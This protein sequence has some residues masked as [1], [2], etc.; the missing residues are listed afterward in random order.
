M[1]SDIDWISVSDNNWSDGINGFE[2]VWWA[3]LL[4]KPKVK[5]TLITLPATLVS[6][7]LDTVMGLL[8]QSDKKKKKT[9][10]VQAVFVICCCYFL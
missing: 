2:K 7:H 5:D 3:F 1:I 4:K 10:S 6:S 8:N 9:I